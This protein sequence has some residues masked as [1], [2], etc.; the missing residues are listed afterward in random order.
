[1]HKGLIIYP[2]LPILSESMCINDAGYINSLYIFDLS[3]LLA[4]VNRHCP[5]KIYGT[6]E[7]LIGI[8]CPL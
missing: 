2:W 8:A 1:M 7:I 3:L 4:C 5:G 6:N